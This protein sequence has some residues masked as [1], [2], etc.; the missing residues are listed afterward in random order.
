MEMAAQEACLP[1]Q[2]E[3]GE[4][5]CPRPKR[6]APDRKGKYGRYRCEY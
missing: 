3:N 5:D 4:Q 6:L 2:S 1:E